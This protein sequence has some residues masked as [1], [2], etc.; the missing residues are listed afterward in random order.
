MTATQAP[1]TE[2]PGFTDSH[3]HLLADSARA[4]LPWQGSAVAEF[5]RRVAACG[6]H[7]NGPARARARRSAG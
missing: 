3:T 6:Q 5:H 1:A 2:V 4:P 7:A